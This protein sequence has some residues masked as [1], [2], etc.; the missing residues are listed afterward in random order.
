MAYWLF[1]SEPGAWSWDDQV[2]TDIEG[3]DGVRNHQACNNM[4]A[5]KIG[6][7]GFFYHSVKE[8]TIVGIVEV[9]K[10]WQPDP[11]QPGE[12]WG[13]PTVK[14]VVGYLNDTLFPSDS[15]DTSDEK[16]DFYDLQQ[17]SEEETEALLLQELEDIDF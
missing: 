8:K 16:Q 5:M 17:L 15:I 13:Y 6:D 1:K 4:R 10:A 12:P 3:W 7:Q 11:N 14:A 2:N 9:V